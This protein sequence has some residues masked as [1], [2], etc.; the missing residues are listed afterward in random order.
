MGLRCARRGAHIDGHSVRA[1]FCEV[2][3]VGGNG[4]ILHF[5]FQAVLI[6][7]ALVLTIVWAAFVFYVDEDLAVLGTRRAD[8]P[9][10]NCWVVQWGLETQVRLMWTKV[11]FA[12][13]VYV[14]SFV[15][16][17][18]FGIRQL[19]I[20]QVMDEACT[21]HMDYCAHID[22]IPL[23]DGNVKVEDELI[24]FFEEKTSAS[25]VGVSVCWDM[26]D[27]AEVCRSVLECGLDAREQPDEDE[28]EGVHGGAI[29][30]GL[31]SK[32]SVQSS[33]GGEEKPKT[34]VRTILDHIEQIALGPGTQWFISKGSALPD[35]K[36]MKEG[37]TEAKQ[38]SEALERRR[39][40]QPKKKPVEEEDEKAMER[41]GTSSVVS[42]V[43][44]EEVDTET[45][46]KGFTTSG[47]AFIV[48]QTE[49]DR[50]A[51][52]EACKE[53]DLT[54][55]GSE[56]KI[57][58]KHCEP[59][60]I[61]WDNYERVETRDRVIRAAKGFGIISGALFVWTFGFYLP[62]A[63]YAM[64]FNYA[65]GQE[66]GAIESLTF[67]MVVVAGN[68]I[69]YLVCSEV[70]ER[71]RFGVLGDRETCYLLLYTF[72]CV[73]NVVLDLYIAYRV[74]YRMMVGVGMK[75][76]YG[77]PL[78]DVDSFAERF[79]TYAMQRELGS[80]LMDYA[81]PSTF[82]IPFLIEP[83][84]TIMLPYQLMV[85]F[86]RTHPELAGLDCERCLQAAPLDLSRYADL[87]LNVILAVMILYFPGG[88]NIKMFL[89]LALSHI[90]IYAFDHWRVLYSVPA[91]KFS[92]ISAD[93]WAQWMCSIPIG[94]VLACL[95][96][97]AHTE[98]L[99]RDG[100][101]DYGRRSY[102]REREN[103]MMRSTLAFFVHVIV[104]TLILVYIVPLFG[105]ASK[106]PSKM[107]YEFTAKSLP[108][109]WFSSNPVY[110]LRSEY[111]YKHDPPSDYYIQ[112][113]EHLIRENRDIGVYFHEASKSEE[114][115]TYGKMLST[116]VSGLLDRSRSS[117]SMST[118][119]V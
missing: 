29:S 52:I 15:G 47:Q 23:L 12:A 27:Q 68:A 48:F 70:A 32:R 38:R 81:F 76:Y 36:E 66:P 17:I 40:S 65:H 58:Q 89:T 80:T 77:T 101:E 25:I 86:V 104:H 59:E 97:K 88:F 63:Y 84:V 2:V 19:R 78:E 44:V 14:F 100:D 24:K 1:F 56:L 42:E 55:R 53:Q 26:G 9:W 109:S 93:W 43:V 94:L 108:C 57:H 105:K 10:E 73:F 114:E 67:S 106:E 75:T 62:Y 51:A 21:T 4:I 22:G 83:I 13:F 110:C 54:Y 33:E 85:F 115:D 98:E 79:E 35:L 41:K 6:V 8:T 28:E 34:L 112:G 3:D 60:S 18:L 5:N 72:A 103:V 69:M 107:E 31:Q 116:G 71:Q 64:S 37:N 102:T 111:V 96:F 95:V 49:V 74:A 61:L 39:S 99:D 119:K 7:W 117:A 82:L 20:S 45:M 90:F 46:V 30:P 92:K 11:A 118:S 50:D 87:L 16:V 91:C 113:K